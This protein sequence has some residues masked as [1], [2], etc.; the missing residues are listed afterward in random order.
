MGFPTEMLEVVLAE[1]LFQELPPALV[2]EMTDTLD[3]CYPYH[4]E[5]PVHSVI[6]R[7]TTFCR[8]LRYAY[9]VWMPETEQDIPLES[10][11]EEWGIDDPDTL[12]AFR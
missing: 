6:I 12:V 3:A 10:L 2:D 5:E 9:D 4:P 8:H 11:I 7:G 1:D